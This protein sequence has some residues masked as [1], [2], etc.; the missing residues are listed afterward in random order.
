MSLNLTHKVLHSRLDDVI[1]SVSKDEDDIH[2]VD[3][4]D[5]DQDDSPAQ[6]FSILP[7]QDLAQATQ[8]WADTKDEARERLDLSLA[9]RSAEL[10]LTLKVS[11]LL[12]EFGKRVRGKVLLERTAS[13]VMFL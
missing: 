1:D 12:P 9:V 3:S 10:I 7:K 13:Q 11:V 5:E 8:A 6:E 2:S 4:L